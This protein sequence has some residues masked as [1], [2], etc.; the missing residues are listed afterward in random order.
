MKSEIEDL[1]ITI[2][3]AITIQVLNLLDSFFAQ[4]FGILIYKVRKKEKF[5]TLKN[6]TK[7]LKDEEF[8]IKN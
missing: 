6:L 2:D 1:K 7:S 8:Q 3:E 4:F 5:S